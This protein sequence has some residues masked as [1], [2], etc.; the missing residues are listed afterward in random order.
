[1]KIKSTNL[2]N[3]GESVEYDTEKLYD[4]A[5]PDEF[6]GALD[7]VLEKHGWYLTYCQRDSTIFGNYQRINGALEIPIAKK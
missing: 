7:L 3:N 1:M 6:M 4:P 2:R 5:E